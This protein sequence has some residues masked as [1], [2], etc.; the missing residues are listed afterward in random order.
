MSASGQRP[1][2]PGAVAG[3]VTA[4]EPFQLGRAARMRDGPTV[5]RARP[6]GCRAK[7]C[8]IEAERNN[9][10]ADLA[11]ALEQVEGWRTLAEYRGSRLVERQERQTGHHC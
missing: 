6:D 5:V 1:E 9:L 8:E 2:V 4:V 7:F 11:E 3:H 10:R